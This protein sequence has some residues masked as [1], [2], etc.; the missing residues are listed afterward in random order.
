MWGLYYTVLLNC[1]QLV[2]IP[3]TLIFL[4]DKKHSMWYLR[5]LNCFLISKFV[6]IHIK[7]Y[8]LKWI[9]PVVLHFDLIHHKDVNLK[10]YSEQNV[11]PG[12]NRKA[13]NRSVNATGCWRFWYLQL[14]WFF[15]TAVTEWKRWLQQITA[16]VNH[17]SFWLK[18]CKGFIS[19]QLC[20]WITG[21]VTAQVKDPCKNLKLWL[22]SVRSLLDAPAVVNPL[23]KICCRVNITNMCSAPAYQ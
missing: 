10:C 2:R 16:H 19:I 13:S 8:M 7:Q 17:I 18:A 5:R 14:L 9:S 11:H 3:S 15:M 20:H 1:S 12:G 21:Q 23:K 22:S 6:V 4:K